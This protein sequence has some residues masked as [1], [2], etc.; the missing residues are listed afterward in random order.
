MKH[1]KPTTPGQR[2]AVLTDYSVLSGKRK[3]KRLVTSFHRSFGRSRGRITVRH[4]GGGNKRLYRIIDFK[5]SKLNIPATVKALEY[6]PNRTGFIALLHYNDGDKRYI[7]AATEMK[8]GDSVN[9]S[10]KRIAL[11]PGNRMPLAHFPI[12]SFVH[13]IEIAPGRGGMLVRSA[14]AS[15]KVLAHEGKHTNIQMPSGEVRK[16]LS[17]G[18]ASSGAVS[19]ASHEEEVLG[20]AG[21]ARWRG[22]RPTV[23]G[24]AMN[25]VDHP[26]GGGEG[27]TGIG[28]RRGPK[29][30]WGK[31]AFGVKT[32][33]KKKYSNVFI[34]SH[35]KSKRR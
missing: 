24:S 12:G 22:I 23:R 7:L 18:Y 28:L 27:R 33:R 21:R 11:S 3:V 4:K 17:V 35:R 16:I 10:D 30:P 32:R 31:L 19:N 26:H 9:T 2:G 20:K 29:T 14:G 1:L 13:N 25:P 15:S 6:D 5:Q 34:V 8:V